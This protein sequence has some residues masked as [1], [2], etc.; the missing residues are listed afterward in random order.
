MGELEGIEL[1]MMWGLELL[2]RDG[3]RRI[4]GRGEELRFCMGWSKRDCGEVSG[5]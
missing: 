2:E 3:D 5:G 4:L 1:G